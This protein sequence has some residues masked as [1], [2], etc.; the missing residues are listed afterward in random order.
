MPIGWLENVAEAETYFETR[1]GSDDFDNLTESTGAYYKTAV[2]TTAYKRLYYCPDF[3]IPSSPTAAQLAKLKDAQC[4]TALYMAI[5]LT[6]EDRRKG[7]QAQGVIDAGIVKETY[8]K[9]S[10]NKLPI[11]P[12]VFEILVDFY[13]Y[14]ESMVMVDIDRDEDESVDEDVTD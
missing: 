5:H 7:L 12:I 11:P 8:D 3:S 6:D 10:L 14:G 4:E 2:L 13:K 9:D 1:Y